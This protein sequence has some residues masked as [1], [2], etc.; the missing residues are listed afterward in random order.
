MITPDSGL[1]DLL[2]PPGAASPDRIAR[3]TGGA[4]ARFDA[5]AATKLGELL[6]AIAAIATGGAAALANQRTDSARL[7]LN[8]IK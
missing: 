5:G 7:L 3:L 1:R 4:Y 8:Q 2:E 6:R